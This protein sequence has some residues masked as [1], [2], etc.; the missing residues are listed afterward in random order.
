MTPFAQVLSNNKITP[1]ETG[2]AVLDKS[3]NVTL[4]VGDFII[5]LEPRSVAPHKV[6]DTVL[7]C[8]THEGR[9]VAASFKN[10]QWS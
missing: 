4:K 8:A 5:A 10:G 2:H 6:G 1:N 3:G 9:Q 7:V